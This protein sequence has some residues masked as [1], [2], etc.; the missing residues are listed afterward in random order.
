L[1]KP[2]GVAETL[3]WVQAL[4]AIGAEDLSGD[5]ATDTLGSVIKDRD[6]L[7]LVSSDIGRVVDG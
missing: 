4:G 2:P 7:E 6:D 5:A 3:D 1:A